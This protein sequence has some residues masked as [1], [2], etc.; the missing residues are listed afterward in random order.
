MRDPALESGLPL[1][2]D[3]TARRRDFDLLS[4]LPRELSAPQFCCLTIIQATCIDQEFSMVDVGMGQSWTSV[5]LLSSNHPQSPPYR[6]SSLDHRVRHGLLVK[7][8]DF[9]HQF[10]FQVSK[11]KIIY[12]TI[13]IFMSVCPSVHVASVHKCLHCKFGTTWG[14]VVYEKWVFLD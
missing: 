13:L 3:P 10:H 4:A 7:G 2:W 14:W 6:P 12:I 11:F 9:L 1:M 5:G 8:W